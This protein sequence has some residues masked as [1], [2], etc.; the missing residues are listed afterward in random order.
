MNATD[1]KPPISGLDPT[2]ITALSLVYVAGQ[3]SAIGNLPHFTTANGVR[4][5][6]ESGA[7]VVNLGFAGAECE[8]SSA[9]AFELATMMAAAAEALRSIEASGAVAAK[10][11]AEV[12]NTV[13]FGL[14]RAARLVNDDHQ[15][16][17]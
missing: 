5:G 12:Q 11:E 2:V 10:L 6:I 7:N 1:A 15:A 16:A 3:R 13:A 9:D 4:I 8:L 17:S 14:P